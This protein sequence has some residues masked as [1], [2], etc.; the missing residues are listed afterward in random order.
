MLAC[1][2]WHLT[3]LVAARDDVVRVTR[4]QV[5]CR[6]RICLTRSLED[7]LWLLNRI[8]RT[9][10]MCHLHLSIVKDLLLQVIDLALL[11]VRTSFHGA[12][13]AVVLV[14]WANRH[15]VETA[16]RNSSHPDLDCACWHIELCL[17][18][19]VLTLVRNTVSCSSCLMGIESPALLH[20]GCRLDWL[21]GGNALT[22]IASLLQLLR[23]LQ[24]A[25]LVV[26]DQQVA[27][28]VWVRRL[29]AIRVAQLSLLLK[30]S[31]K[32]SD[33][34]LYETARTN[35]SS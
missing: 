23:L 15:V 22:V 6:T 31:W 32:T 25:Q 2:S 35:N 21:F 4:V 24:V 18:R 30:E 3:I 8:F 1:S 11:V 5:L 10:R 34:N 7:V 17:T 9:E 28:A 13:C 26:R 20:T 27:P 19:V 16:V 14:T 29:K 33:I 12:Q